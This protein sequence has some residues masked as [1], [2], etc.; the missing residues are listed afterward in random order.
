MHPNRAFHDLDDAAALALAERI[1]FAH[2]FA[3]AGGQPMVAHAPIVRFGPDRFRFHLARSNRLAR[4]LDG[5]TVLLSLVGAH[6]YV[7]PNWYDRPGDQV[8]TW[9]YVA[10]EIDGI[11]RAL[12]EAA[13]TEQLDRLS[14]LH[15]PGLSSSPWTRAKMNPARFDVLRKAICGFEVTVGAVRVTNKLSQNKP[16]HDRVGVIAGLE[17]SG[18]AALALAIR[19]SDS[20]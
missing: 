18:N 1:A 15:E 19:A 13:L 10:V 11:A 3:F 16:A 14:D 8:P 9:N 6:G 20:A 17:A 5:A 7:T 2:V 4:H 12:D